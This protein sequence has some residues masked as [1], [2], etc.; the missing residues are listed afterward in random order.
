MRTA[1]RES[2]RLHA[3]LALLV[4]LVIAL[5]GFAA[6]PGA[7]KAVDVGPWLHNPATGHYYQQVGNVT[8]AQA[9][10]YAVSV[11]GHLVTLNDQAEQDWLEAAFTQRNLWIGMNDRA[12]EGSWV[13]SSGEPVTYTHWSV[14]EPNDANQGED[15]AVMNWLH[16]NWP[17]PDPQPLG[18]NDLPEDGSQGAIVEAASSTV[19]GTVYHAGVPLV[20]VEVWLGDDRYVCTNSS[21]SFSVVVPA[22]E[23]F[24]AATGPSV[25]LGCA[26]NEFLDPDTG[27]P[28]V[29]QYWDHTNG[30]FRGETT[31]VAPGATVDIRFDVVQAA[32]TQLVSVK[33]KTS[34]A[35]GIWWVKA[36]NRD[37]PGF[38]AAYGGHPKKD[39]YPAIWMSSTG[40]ISHDIVGSMSWFGPNVGELRYAE[41]GDVLVLVNGGSYFE[42]VGTVEGVL[43]PKASFTDKNHDGVLEGRQLE[44]QLH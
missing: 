24:P 8:W 39:L 40:A 14:G 30:V 36:F 22:D 6:W 1:L 33:V 7:A 11:G 27:L 12:V 29:T 34:P 21:G 9:E 4:G 10:T 17:G 37:D 15:A 43:I 16:A 20:G 31:T 3:A 35:S 25:A 23:P 2:R 18:W 38:I 13:W 42:P 44:I 32:A 5:A 26:N 41:L 28:L 19:T